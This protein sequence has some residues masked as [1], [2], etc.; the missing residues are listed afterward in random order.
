LPFP[1]ADRLV[2]VW[3]T[4]PNRPGQK[5]GTNALGY[6]T[7]R[8]NN[9]VFESVGAARLDAA[10]NVS[11]DAPGGARERVPVQWFTI[12]LAHVLG[13]Q[14]ILGRWP[15]QREDN[16]LVIGYGLWQRMFGGARD[17]VGKPLRADFGAMP[18]IAVLPR[19]FELLRPDVGFWI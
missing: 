19:E 1:D 15:N 9:H 14:P 12:D 2:A 3:F 7:V 18:V 17:V 4:P 11:D 5:A 10:F 16:V 6:F 13:I 8:D